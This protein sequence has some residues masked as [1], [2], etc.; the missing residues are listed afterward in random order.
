MFLNFII[1]LCS[2]LCLEI[3]IL[4]VFL[5]VIS[6]IKILEFQG[7]INNMGRNVGIEPTNNGTTIHRVNHF[8]NSAITI[9]ILTYFFDYCNYYL[10]NNLLL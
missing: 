8:T 4:L 7:L 3:I 1:A 6:K 9:L 2:L 5:S 10:K